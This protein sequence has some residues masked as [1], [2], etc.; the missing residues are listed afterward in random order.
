[1]A[2]LD[3]GSECYAVFRVVETN[4]VGQ[5]V[6]RYLTNE[7]MAT[8]TKSIPYDDEDVVPT[9][10]VDSTNYGPTASQLFKLKEY[11][12]LGQSIG[13]RIL[14]MDPSIPPNPN[15]SAFYAPRDITAITNMNSVYHDGTEEYV[16]SYVSPIGFS[17]DTDTFESLFEFEIVSQIGDKNVVRLVPQFGSSAIEN[18]NNYGHDYPTDFK[19]LFGGDTRHSSHV[20]ESVE[21]TLTLRAPSIRIGSVP[22]WSGLTPVY[23]EALFVIETFDELP[24]I[25]EESLETP[26]FS[27]S[28]YN[29]SR[30]GAGDV[31]VS[32]IR[33]NPA[34]HNKMQF[35]YKESAS[36][37]W[38]T[39]EYGSYSEDLVDG[40]YTLPFTQTVSLTAE[41]YNKTLNIRCRG[42]DDTVTPKIATRWAEASVTVFISPGLVLDSCY[43]EI[44]SSKDSAR[45]VTKTHTIGDTGSLQYVKMRIIGEDGEAISDYVTSTNTTIVHDVANNVMYRLPT[46]EEQIT[47]Q[48]SI[49]TEYGTVVEDDLT[50]TFTYDASGL[51]Q[52]TITYSTDGS[53]S[54]VVESERHADDLCYL[55]VRNYEQKIK[56]VRCPVL[57]MGITH[58]RWIAIPCLN[59]D[60][61]IIVVSKV[62]NNYGYSIATANVHSHNF[63]WNWSKYKSTEPYD[64][65]AIVIVNTDNPPQQSRTFKTDAQ[66]ISPMGRMFP[67]SFATKML[68]TSLNIEGIIVDEDANYYAPNPIP[69]NSKLSHVAKLVRLSGQ[70]IHPIYRTPYGDWYQVAIEQVDLSKLE[71]NKSK[72]SVTQRAVED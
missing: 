45:I 48:Y 29:F 63:I 38:T 68:D 18:L 44:D 15:T 7:A 9:Y 61:E 36:T 28:T 67:V 16:V 22:S 53:D 57:S 30:E 3:L 27:D 34:G 26:I 69:D 24:T 13:Y 54:V 33:V 55:M 39:V 2:N 59:K 31:T 43:F 25:V 8:V 52:P 56:M 6:N 23:K 4:I 58:I 11:V 47:L 46:D 17:H 65:F 62:G 20:I 5:T 72:V 35:E 71:L 40:Y 42:F 37:E 70:G 19:I 21:K 50:T 10:M 41:D 32:Q 12:S 49:I 66:F 64:E 51:I 1:M 14:P 60:S